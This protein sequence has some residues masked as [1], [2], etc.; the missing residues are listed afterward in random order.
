MNPIPRVVSTRPFNL[1]S[2]HA[3]SSRCWVSCL[4]LLAACVPIDSALAEGNPVPTGDIFY[5][6]PTGNDSNPGTFSSPLASLTLAKNLASI[7]IKQQDG[8]GNYL[9]NTAT[10][11]LRAGEYPLLPLA[12]Q[13]MDP[14][15]EITSVDTRPGATIT[16]A[17]APGEI[18]T[19]HG[20]ITIP[21]GGGTIGAWETVPTYTALNGGGSSAATP[22]GSKSVTGVKKFVFTGATRQYL[23]DRRDALQAQGI[24]GGA[25]TISQ[26]FGGIPSATPTRKTRARH[27][28]AKGMNA[29]TNPF[30]GTVLA[31]Q[32]A[33]VVV[34]ARWFDN[35][36]NDAD[37][38]GLNLI[39]DGKTEFIFTRIYECP[40]AIITAA[41]LTSGGS[42]P[43]ATLEF[44]AMQGDPVLYPHETNLA[45]VNK[46]AD[47]L[48]SG[49]ETWNRGIAENNILFLDRE[50]E[51]YFDDEA[52][53]L[54]YF[55]PAGED[56]TTRQFRIPITHTLIKMR[57]TEASL[58]DGVK[59]LGS[60]VG[61]TNPTTTNPNKMGLRFSWTAWRFENGR[62]NSSFHSFIQGAYGLSAA[63]DGMYITNTSVERVD[64]RGIGA[65]A[66]SLGGNRLWNAGQDD[67]EDYYHQPRGI[68]SRCVVFD[69]FM[70]DLG[71]AGV[72]LDN[73]PRLNSQ[74]F[75]T[76]PGDPTPLTPADDNRI[77]SNVI[78]DTGNV[79]Y[80]S[81]TILVMRSINT[82]VKANSIQ[83]TPYSAISTGIGCF[84]VN[85][86]DSL[87]MAD[88]NGE[89]NVVEMNG[90]VRA[91]RRLMDG[92]AI[93]TWGGSHTRI[94]NNTIVDTAGVRDSF[95]VMLPGSTT[96]Y[97]AD[98]YLDL[99]S[100]HFNTYQN[101]VTGSLG[102]GF[103]RGTTHTLDPLL[104]W[105]AKETRDDRECPN[106]TDEDCC[107]TP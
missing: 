78:I 22:A 11:Y 52:V 1:P 62:G 92:A 17:N 38:F 20:A 86:V 32:E 47:A 61:S 13:P 46:L 42:T 58:V 7:R 83:D 77:E 54:Y 55:P 15:L 4:L 30:D 29:D 71:G 18:A 80:D 56:V 70:H 87:G 103:R 35:N 100:R 21:A 36:T 23:A 72:R 84:K 50:D 63:I 53:E 99:T 57:G 66:I 9:T 76:V 102:R 10:I 81:V 2:R 34:P 14:G 106:M 64:M 41:T 28:N 67:R 90:V 49:A 101:S 95:A 74:R 24:N 16:I 98:I 82:L 40:R 59:I 68:V 65:N 19:V 51:W 60:F 91:M 33:K 105:I 37:G 44:G 69:N 94:N 75:W 85:K 79:F 26:L 48:P 31:D 45:E 97:V 104:T 25:F 96:D 73:A 43:R 107:T 3:R 5:V 88:G 89:R 39:A 12:T 93:Y 8:S 6:S 27:P